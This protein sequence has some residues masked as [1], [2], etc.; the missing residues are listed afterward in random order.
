MTSED[1][2]ASNSS[3]SST[4]IDPLQLYAAYDFDTDR[5]YQV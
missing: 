2:V 1:P 4:A 3:Q 5:L